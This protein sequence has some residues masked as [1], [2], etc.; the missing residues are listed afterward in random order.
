[1]ATRNSIR[2]PL[3]EVFQAVNVNHADIR[4][5]DMQVRWKPKR[6]L[7]LVMS[8]AR[9]SISSTDLLKKPPNDRDIRDSAP[10]NNFSGLAIFKLPDS[11][12]AS[13]GLYRV[14]VM[15]WMDDGD[16]T[17]AYTRIDARVAKQL[18]LGGHPAELAVVGQN[19]GADYT[20]FRNDNI[21]DRRVYGSISLS[22]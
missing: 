2:F 1:M 18:S 21:F 19:L 22:W 9:V 14:G 20:E 7:D 12:E 8:Y 15:K 13:V 16:I 17:R 5:A 4:G 6:W 11:W 10:K 3:T